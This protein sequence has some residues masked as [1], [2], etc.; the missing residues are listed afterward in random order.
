MRS[1]TSDLAEN[2]R[3]TAEMQDLVPALWGDALESPLDDA[4]ACAQQFAAWCQTEQIMPTTGPNW[5]AWR[6]AWI[7]SKQQQ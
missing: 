5:R 2:R 7:L 3:L 6:H 4:K 1:P